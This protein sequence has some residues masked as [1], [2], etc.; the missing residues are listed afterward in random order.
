[1]ARYHLGNIYYHTGEIDNAI[2]SYKDY[3]S[4]ASSDNSGIK[5]L[6]SDIT[7]VLL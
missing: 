3:V 6:A 4:S 5:F 7:R 2:A 1:M